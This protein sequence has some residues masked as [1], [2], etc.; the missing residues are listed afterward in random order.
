MKRIHIVG[1][2]PEKVSVIKEKLASK[3]F[4]LVEE[5]PEIVISYGGDG[6]FLI[7]ERI[8]PGVPKILLRD[9]EVGNMT[10]D[11]DICEIIDLYVQGKFSME[12]THKLK[13]IRR[14]L[15]EVRELIGVNDIVIR[16]SLPTEAIR[17][18][19]RVNEGEWSSVLIGDGVVVST[20]YGSNKGAYFHSIVRKKFDSGIG[21]AFNNVTDEREPLYLCD[22]DCLEV[23]IVRGIGV[24]VADNN[25]DSINLESGDRIK[26]NLIGD[27]ARRV[28][29]N[30]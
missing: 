25:R 21:V 26:V 2:S 14:G 15:F 18:R 4:C 10:H 23:E 1:K 7:A 24:M 6:M 3:G 5:N 11:L 16:N 22:G 28:V 19:Y 29:F 8:F 12:E 20:P 9:S 17:F 30:G 13:A 27:V